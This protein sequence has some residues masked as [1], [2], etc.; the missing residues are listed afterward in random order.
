MNRYFDVNYEMGTTTVDTCIEGGEKVT[1]NKILFDFQEEVDDINDILT[2]HDKSKFIPYMYAKIFK[3][4]NESGNRDVTSFM[5][6]THIGECEGLPSCLELIISAIDMK[7]ASNHSDSAYTKFYS[8]IAGKLCFPLH[9]LMDSRSAEIFSEY[10]VSTYMTSSSFMMI[11][12][13][14]SHAH[15]FIKRA[16]RFQPLSSMEVMKCISNFSVK[17]HM[18]NDK[19][20]NRCIRK[21]IRKTIYAR[22]NIPTTQVCLRDYSEEGMVR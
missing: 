12:N 2:N 1:I 11:L 22:H 5:G 21:N 9:K 16:V 18:K 4:Y 13:E 3:D 8:S 7:M 15:L 6:F 10:L 19:Y 20:Y 14:V 17:E